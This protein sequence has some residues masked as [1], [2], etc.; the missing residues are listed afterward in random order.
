MEPLPLVD[1]LL[2]LAYLLT[3]VLAQEHVK[4][5]MAV[6]V[7]VATT[8]L[9]ELMEAMELDRI[10]ALDKVLQHENLENPLGLCMQVE[11]MVLKAQ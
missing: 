4:V 8:E 9:A 6:L 3:V 2:H 7:E 10:L 11:E 1:L 5:V